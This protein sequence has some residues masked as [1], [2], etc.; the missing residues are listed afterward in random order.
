M[1]ELLGLG[2]TGLAVLLFKLDPPLGRAL[3][4]SII[5]MVVTVMALFNASEVGSFKILH[6][7]ITADLAR[8][9]SLLQ[10]LIVKPAIPPLSASQDQQ[11]KDQ[12]DFLAEEIKM[13]TSQKN[14]I[15]YQVLIWS[16]SGFLFI[17]TLIFLIW[18]STVIRPPAN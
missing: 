5:V 6:D 1:Y 15:I 18:L 11:I 2:L 14:E 7:K 9:D 10:A 12:I 8:K 13:M 4:K 17:L 3:T 16:L